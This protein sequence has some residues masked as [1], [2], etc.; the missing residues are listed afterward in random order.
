MTI[1][2][3]NTILSIVFAIIIVL[4]GW[5]LVRSIVL[6]Y[7]QVEERQAMT[8][9]VRFRMLN[10]RDVLIRYEQRNDRYPPTQGGLDSLM[11]FMRTDSLMQI[12]GDSLL[13]ANS[14]YQLNIDS[15]IYS[16]R[17]PHERFEYASTDTL[18]RPIYVLKDP[19]SDDQIGSLTNSTLL[20]TPNW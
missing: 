2:R 1:D 10:I 6:P 16:P 18:I 9:H 5:W 14:P 19:G 13:T 15:L 12:I 17:P 8:E 3:R 20:N 11:D 4:L 7:Q